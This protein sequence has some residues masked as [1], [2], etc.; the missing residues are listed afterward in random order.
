MVCRVARDARVQRRVDRN[1]FRSPQGGRFRE[2]L[3]RFS[4]ALPPVLVC[5]VARDARVQRRVDRNSF[6]SSRGARYSQERST[7]SNRF[8][9]CENCYKPVYA[10]RRRAEA[11][12][13]AR[14]SPPARNAN[15]NGDSIDYRLSAISYD[16]PPALQGKARLVSS[17]RS[18]F[19][20]EVGFSASNRRTLRRCRTTSSSHTPVCT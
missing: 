1:S 10:W 17:H 3:S 13:Y 19:H 8:N 11:L 12:G 18:P 4:D 7:P 9:M 5:R 14:R 2:C 6:R 16:R 15:S 20:R